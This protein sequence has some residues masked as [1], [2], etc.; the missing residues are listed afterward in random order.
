MAMDVCVFYKKQDQYLSAIK[1]EN[2]FKIGFFFPL[3]YFFFSFLLVSTK[4]FNKLSI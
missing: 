2:F 3:I 4:M 1:A